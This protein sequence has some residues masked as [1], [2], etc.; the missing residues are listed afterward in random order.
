[1]TFGSGAPPGPYDSVWPAW[2]LS[3]PTPTA[4]LVTRVAAPSLRSTAMYWSSDE[5]FGLPPVDVAAGQDRARRVVPVGVRHQVDPLDREDLALEA[6]AVRGGVVERLQHALRAVV[7]VREVEG[8]LGVA[9]P[10]PRTGRSASRSTR[11]RCR[12]G[13]RCRRSAAAAARRP[14]AQHGVLEQPVER[15]R[16]RRRRRRPS[17]TNGGLRAALLHGAL[18]WSN[19]GLRT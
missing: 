11:R 10:G 17:G 13:G 7:G 16:R 4:M 6:L 9:S 15:Q 8:G 2:V 1:M 19:S 18:R 12:A 14:P 5:F 3:S